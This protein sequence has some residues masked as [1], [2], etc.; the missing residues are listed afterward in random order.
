MLELHY[1][2]IQFLIKVNTQGSHP[3]SQKAVIQ[4]GDALLR[5]KQP[6]SDARLNLQASVHC[7]FCTPKPCFHKITACGARSKSIN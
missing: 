3:T 5:S 2:M 6:V 7:L 4:K 1:P